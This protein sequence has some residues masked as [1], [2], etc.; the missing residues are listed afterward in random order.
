MNIRV[1][2]VDDHAVVRD[3]LTALLHAHSDIEVVGSFGE[4]R[5]ALLAAARMQPQVAILD[6]A[7]LRLNGIETAR[8]FHD[9]FPEVSLLMLSMYADT[10]HVNQALRAG[11]I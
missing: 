2:L 11:A 7:M 10:E 9:E 6:I 3:G 4:G 5:E 8:L 1:I